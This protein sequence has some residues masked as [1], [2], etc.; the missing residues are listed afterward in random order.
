MQY[1]VAGDS[2]YA[3]RIQG[4]QGLNRPN[5]FAKFANILHKFS[6]LILQQLLVV[7]SQLLTIHNVPQGFPKIDI[8]LHLQGKNMIKRC[9]Q[10]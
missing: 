2:I 1:C 8:M 9:L 10:L 5:L 3:I 7:H 4:S 6:L